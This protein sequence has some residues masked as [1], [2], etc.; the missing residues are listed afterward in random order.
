MLMSEMNECS[1]DLESR[2]QN[3]MYCRPGCLQN[4]ECSANLGPS[5]CKIVNVLQIWDPSEDL[6]KARRKPWRKQRKAIWRK[7]P[8]KQLEKAAFFGERSF[9][10]NIQ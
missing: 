4:A 6:E 8:E 9:L 2:G 3:V 10:S 1:K 7:H 5:S